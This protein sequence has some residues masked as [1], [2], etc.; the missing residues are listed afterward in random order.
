[1]AI[2][3]HPNLTG[4]FLVWYGLFQVSSNCASDGS[5][6][7]LVCDG[8]KFDAWAMS[9]S[10]KND[11]CRQIE[12]PGDLATKV[13]CYEAMLI[14]LCPEPGVAQFPVTL[15]RFGRLLSDKSFR[16]DLALGLYVYYDHQ[17]QE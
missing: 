5:F 3:S 10:K 11:I 15:I 6:G 4:T 12:P 9:Q 2:K 14:I 8:A 7:N 1:L 17:G 16:L 13:S